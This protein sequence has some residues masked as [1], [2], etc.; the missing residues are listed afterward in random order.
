MITSF[1]SQSC[2]KFIYPLITHK[3]S[4]LRMICRIHEIRL[5][6]L[7]NITIQDFIGIVI[8]QISP[9]IFYHFIRMQN[10]RPYLAS[11][12]NILF[13]FIFFIDL[14]IL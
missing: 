11:P 1:L 9:V 3:Y 2:Y 8:F 7:I 5:N 4:K 12:G 14:F 13:Q 6:E 10:V